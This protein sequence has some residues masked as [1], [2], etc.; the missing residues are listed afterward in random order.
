MT[1]F[2]VVGG[3]Y[4]DTSFCEAVGGDE[5]WIG[6][7]SNY[8]SAQKEWSRRAWLTVDDCT[9]RFRIERVDADAPPP[10]TD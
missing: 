9:T 5:E 7:F 3:E 1:Q 6:P 10:C 2:F 4:A 8:E